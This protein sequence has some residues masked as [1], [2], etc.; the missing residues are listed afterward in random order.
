[1]F[2]CVSPQSVQMSAHVQLQLK[3][4]AEILLKSEW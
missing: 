2:P 3:C 1:M 4:T